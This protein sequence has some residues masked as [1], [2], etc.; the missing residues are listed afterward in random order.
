MHGVALGHSS[1]SNGGTLSCG[2]QVKIPYSSK[3]AEYEACLARLKAALDINI[4]IWKF[5]EI[6][7]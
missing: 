4:K 6:L 1:F 5:T 3:M 7:S 2:N